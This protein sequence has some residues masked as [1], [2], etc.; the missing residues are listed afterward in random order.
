M[1]TLLGIILF[2]LLL[3]AVIA[4]IELFPRHSDTIT[5]V[6][7]ISLLVGGFLAVVIGYNLST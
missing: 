6:I 3:I 2:K 1:T 4:I 5:N 7:V